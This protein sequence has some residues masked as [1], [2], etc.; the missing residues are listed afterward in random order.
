MA[1]QP[2]RRRTAYSSLRRI[3]RKMRVPMIVGPL[4]PRGKPR[5]PKMGF[6]VSEDGEL[7]PE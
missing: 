2:Q 6:L 7:S 4:L 3:A 1:N 5:K